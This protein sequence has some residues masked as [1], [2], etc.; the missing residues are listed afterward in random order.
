[1]GPALKDMNKGENVLRETISNGRKIMPKYG[2]KLS[3]GEIDA[4]VAHIKSTHNKGEH[5]SAP[6]IRGVGFSRA[7]DRVHPATRSWQ[8]SSISNK[9]VAAGRRFANGTNCANM[10]AP[11]ALWALLSRL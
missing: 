6:A 11:M 2:G 10:G 4:L 9:G 5:A 1:M 8:C 7:C 3:A